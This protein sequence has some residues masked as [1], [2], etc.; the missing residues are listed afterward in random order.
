MNQFY[1][2]LF[3][4]AV[5]FG[6]GFLASAQDKPSIYFSIDKALENPENVKVLDLSFQAISD[7][8]DIFNDLP[9]L[10]ALKLRNNKIQYL[11]NSV[12]NLKKL[13]HLDLAGNIFI[14]QEAL[15]VGIDSLNSLEELNL[16]NCNIKY[17]DYSVGNCQELKS[18]N[19]KG[20]FLF[21]L[22]Y[23]VGM[24]QNL[25]NLNLAKNLL[26]ELPESFYRLDELRSLN[27]GDNEILEMGQFF[28]FLTLLNIENLQFQ[29]QVIPDLVGEEF[30]K[31]HSLE[32]INCSFENAQI[33]EKLRTEKLE[34]NYCKGI[35]PNT[36]FQSLAK[37]TLLWDFR[38][39]DSSMKKI[40]LRVLA[41]SNLEYIKLELPNIVNW[42]NGSL[43]LNRMKKLST[44]DLSN[45]DIG[46]LPSSLNGL[47]SLK[48]L[49]LNNSE[50]KEGDLNLNLAQLEKLDLR[51]NDLSKNEVKELAKKNP[52]TNISHDYMYNPI[53]AKVRP[54]PK[55]KENIVWTSLDPSVPNRLN[56]STGTEIIIP[57][58]AFVTKEGKPVKGEVEFAV[59]EFKNAT[60]IF[61]SGLPMS[62][63]SAGVTYT[64]SSAGMMELR[65]YSKGEELDL[66]PDKQL[67]I[68]MTSEQ[69]GKFNLYSLDDSTGA[70]SVED[71]GLNDTTSER[72]NP[73]IGQ[74]KTRDFLQDSAS[75]FSAQL[76]SFGP[77][78][79][80][81]LKFKVRP[82]KKLNSFKINFFE[83][84]RID[85]DR[86]GQYFNEKGFLEKYTFV[87]EGNKKNED[88]NRLVK[89]IEDIDEQFHLKK[90]RKYRP[91]RKIHDS[92]RI[93]NDLVI[94][95][96]AL[97]DNFVLSLSYA[98]EKFSFPVSI[99]TKSYK[100]KAI[101]KEYSKF[102]SKY[103]KELNKRMKMWTAYQ[104]K[105]EANIKKTIEDR[106]ANLVAKGFV[107]EDG[108][109]SIPGRTFN[110]GV[111]GLG[112]INLDK[113]LPIYL[114]NPLEN[115]L[116]KYINKDSKDR[117]YPASIYVLDY[118]QNFALNYRGMKVEA[119]KK[120]E[121]VLVTIFKNG[122]YGIIFDFDEARRNPEGKR[123]LEF[124]IEVFDKSI[125]FNERLAPYVASL[126]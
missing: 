44:L 100:P 39:S 72:R 49:N 12:Y 74:T 61:L 122:D 62:Y 109:V 46:N 95:A 70:W 45:N 56:L 123:K 92:L 41:N 96:N 76:A 17:L 1:R 119:Y 52:N 59:E 85:K 22:P 99:E 101:Q 65:A 5:L 29:N 103:K 14:N 105:R 86:E 104:R 2:F 19:L 108:K 9:N 107:N 118:T 71:T 50:L 87:Y 42:N 53:P 106:W 75:W 93:I 28:Q 97:S 26:V 114:T 23:S 7:L 98:G 37:D 80:E 89:M 117:I 112:I 16:S 36:L 78:Y 57:E 69:E 91:L 31:F 38:L 64:F 20:N 30:S 25:E 40:N 3:S 84:G 67:E 33:L 13:N 110:F 48:E 63:D 88:F 124:E 47:K 60:D 115:F 79:K 58:N 102:Y 116:T 11:P 15:F 51:K 90:N 35:E 77:K 120:S 111:G 32:F 113:P 34:L 54:L 68:K 82:H 21:Y 121:V 18:L 27:I 4:I 83:N 126:N 10:E 43:G 73:F 81:I 125:D 55:M 6:L 94:S 24:L 66:A 8:P